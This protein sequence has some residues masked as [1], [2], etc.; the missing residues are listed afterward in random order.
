MKIQEY[1]RGPTPFPCVRGMEFLSN[2]ICHLSTGDMLREAVANKTENGLRAKAAMDSGAL[3]TDD[4]VFG[5]V[6]DAMKAPECSKGYIIDGLP[7]TLEQARRMEETGIKSDKV[8]SFDVPDEVIIERTSGRWIHRASGRTYHSTFAPPKTHAVD[9]LTGEPLMQRPDD[10]KEVVVKRLE[11]Y[12]REVNPIKDF[13][14]SM[15][16]FSSI[17]GNRPMQAV[18]ETLASILDPV[19]LSL[20]GKLKQ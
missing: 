12:H 4:I 14:R 10:R 20:G 18:R 16:I 19:F 13:Y 9:D 15:G 1:P 11:L 17:D 8:V 3:V 5:I 7:R 6:K 2:E